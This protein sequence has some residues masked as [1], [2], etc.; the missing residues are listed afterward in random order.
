MVDRC[1]CFDKKFSEM[2]LT[3][4][5][6]NIKD[7]NELKKYFLFGENCRLCIPYVELMLNTGKTEFE[8]MAFNKES[9]E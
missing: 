2:K 6:N 8:P 7:I 5:K 1:V 9:N 3:A 4:E